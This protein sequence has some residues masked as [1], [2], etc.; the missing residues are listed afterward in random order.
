MPDALS[1]VHRLAAAT[2]VVTALAGTLAAQRPPLASLRTR[3][4]RSGYRETS[5]HDEV[6]AFMEA[7]AGASPRVQL[8][9]FGY[10]NE[11]RALP[12]AVVGAAGAGS[13]AV[14][15][16]GK[17]RVYLQGNIH[18]GEV[19]GKEVLQAL[20]RSL[21]L[22]EHRE[23]DQSMV[24][25]V[26]P[27]YNADGNERV[28]LTNRGSQNGPVGG[29]GQRPNAQGLDLNRDHM[30][31]DSPEARAVVKLMREYDPHV[32]IDLHTTN[33]SQHA[34][35]L[36]YA[37]PL[38][39]STDP[40]IV[41]L[42]RK[43]WLPALTRNIK[44]KDGWDFYYYGNVSGRGPDRTWATFDHRPRFNNNYVGLRNR[45]ALLSEA[46]SYSTF[47]QRVNSTR[48][49]VEEALA[50]THANAA[51]LRKITA[52]ADARS[53]VGE[54]VGVRAAL[55]KADR[56]VDILMGEVERVRHPYSGQMMNNRLDVSRPEKMWE[57]GTFE[58][59]VSERVPRAYYVPP[60]LAQAI[61]RL[62]A[63]GVAMTPLSADTRIRGEQF[64]IDSNT[65]A[66][67]PFQNHR[68]RTL[69]GVWEAAELTLP[70][71]T[72]MVSMDQPLARLAF[73]LIEPQSD[74]GL[75]DWNL[76][77]EALRDAKTYPIVRVV[78]APGGGGGR[79]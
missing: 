23:W 77:D 38:N 21:A 39:P 61:D 42:L 32:A 14:M 3:A 7:V 51:R 25:L 70:A 4:E 62:Q 58:A 18:A 12:L 28:S 40:A 79:R 45:F 16:S 8:T 6:V 44:Q 37:P 20:L 35:Q 68:E 50:F 33:G 63:H 65:Q 43:E 5:R 60:A 10:T 74:D 13:D 59:T 54:T 72:L 55:K 75:V 17:T 69:T 73:Y 24:L 22:G 53:L 30:K 46:Y 27:I 56:Q 15:R 9:T 64:R 76:L 11:G 52:D 57:A 67:Q 2:L 31:L 41:D 26:A 66:A 48:R 19:E 78:T 29:M 1:S 47:E 36:T 34:Y 49:F 71:G